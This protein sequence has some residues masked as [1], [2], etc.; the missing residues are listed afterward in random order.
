[1]TYRFTLEKYTGINSRFTCPN[2]KTPRKFTLYIDTETGNYVS[3][4]VGRCDRESSCGYH[5]S[6]KDY[7]AENQ[8]SNFKTQER[9]HSRQRQ[10]VKQSSGVEKFGTIPSEILVNTLADYDENYFVQ[11]LQTQFSLE[12]TR[13][14]IRNYLIGTWRDGRTVFWQVD[15]RG[16]VRTGK[17]M[18]YDK[19]TGKRVK[20]RN[21]SWVHSELKNEVTTDSVSYRP[22]EKD[23]R[24]S[25]CFFGEHLV[26]QN[27]DKPIGI[28]ESEKTAIVASLFLPKLIWIATG[29]CGNLNTRRLASVVKGRQTIIFPDSS[30]YG[31]WSAK[32][33]E[34]NRTNNLRVRISDLLERQLNE[35][36]KKLDYDLADFLLRDNSVP[37]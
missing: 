15:A 4:L 37:K 36:Q 1:M 8:G 23:F 7:F 3:E 13:A 24:L 18:L 2:C 17:L 10:S 30:K 11:F 21:V 9:L 34:V 22:I 28:V 31:T 35:Q 16:R 19:T 12:Q 5:Y 29:G 27:E 32:I 33:E 25:Q 20:T 14:V 26:A 6:P